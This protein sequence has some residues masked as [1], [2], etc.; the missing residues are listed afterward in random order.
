MIMGNKIVKVEDSLFSIGGYVL[1]ILRD[2]EISIDKLYIKFSEVYPKVIA[3]DDF[4][5][6]I[7]FLFMINKIKIKKDDI[8]GIIV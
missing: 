3:F 7:D 8:L 6:S 4:V 5:Y 2:K 1:S